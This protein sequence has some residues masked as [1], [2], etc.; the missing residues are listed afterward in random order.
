MLRRLRPYPWESY[1]YC[2]TFWSRNRIVVLVSSFFVTT[3]RRSSG[4]TTKEKAKKQ[5]SLTRKKPLPTTTTNYLHLRT[6]GSH[7]M[8]T[9]R[10]SINYRFCWRSKMVLSL[11]GRQTGDLDGGPFFFLKA[12]ALPLV[13]L[14]CAIPSL[15]LSCVFH[16]TSHAVILLLFSAKRMQG[17]TRLLSLAV[18]CSKF[19]ATQ[20]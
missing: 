2:S 18:P 11:S 17:G 6:H 7:N 12:A 13:P 1:F 10:A 4:K 8:H 14:P 20:V 19:H 3:T 16:S 5:R 9:R 15:S